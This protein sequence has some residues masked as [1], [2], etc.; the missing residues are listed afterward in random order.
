MFKSLFCTRGIAP[1]RKF[2]ELKIYSQAIVRE[3]I[4]SI[5]Y[6]GI[7]YYFITVPLKSPTLGVRKKKRGYP[8]HS[9]AQVAEP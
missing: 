5:S 7:L 6:L 2:V 1:L 4:K 8:L 3:A 9:Y